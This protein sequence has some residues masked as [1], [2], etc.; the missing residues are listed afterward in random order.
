MPHLLF[1][2]TFGSAYKF[3]VLCPKLKFKREIVKHPDGGVLAIDWVGPKVRE[4]RKIIL[5]APGVSGDGYDQ[6]VRYPCN[7]AVVKGYTVGVLIGRG[8]SG[9]PIEISD[10]AKLE[11]LIHSACSYN[12]FGYLIEKV[13]K[14]Y[15]DVFIGALGLSMGSGLLIK[16]AIESGDNCALDGI[17]TVAASFDHH[18]TYRTLHRFWPYLD[19]PRKGM[20][21]LA[22]SAIYKAE[23]ELRKHSSVLEQ[24]DIRLDQLP[25]FKS[26]YEFDDKITSRLSNTRGYDEYYTKSS[27]HKDIIKLKT[28]LFALNSLDDLIVSPKGA[29]IDQFRENSRTILMLTTNGGH[30]GWFQ[31]IFKITRWYPIPCLEFF[32]ALQVLKLKTHH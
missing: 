6:Y 23:K 16:Y 18:L 17:A 22:K 30:V 27:T 11:N 21:E 13:K 14:R 29:P 26:F 24:R 25:Q 8:V 3:D 2:L 9:L 4:S 20:L 28:P 7:S 12:D 10:H 31:G 1:E 5:V 32:D 19:I 15:P